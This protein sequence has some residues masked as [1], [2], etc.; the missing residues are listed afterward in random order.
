MEELAFMMQIGSRILVVTD[1]LQVV[2]MDAS[3][4]PRKMPDSFTV[5][6]SMMSR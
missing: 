5:L 6:F 3:I 2:L 4:F 1:I